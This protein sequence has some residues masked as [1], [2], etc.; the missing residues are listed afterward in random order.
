Q[1]ASDKKAASLDALKA[2]QAQGNAIN[3]GEYT[4]NSYAPLKDALTAAQN[5]IDNPDNHTQA[6]IDEATTAIQ[7]ALDQLSDKADKAELDAAISEA[8]GLDLDNNDTEDKA[9]ADALARAQEVSK[10]DNATAEEVKTATDALNAAM[11]AKDTQDA[12]DK[13]TASLDA[14]K[15]AQAQGNAIDEDGYT[16]NSYAPLKDALTAAQNIIDNPEDHTQAEIDEATTAI[17]DALDQLSDR[18]DKAELDTAIKEAEGLDLDETDAEDKAVID[19][20]A[21]AK[22]VSENGNATAE[23]VKT[24]T[25]ALNTAM[26]A[27]D[28]QDASDKKAASLDALKAA[29]AQGNAINEGEY[30]PN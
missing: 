24:A 3:E 16:P 11:K 12:S 4:P 26:K 2:A 21:T 20:L 28:T 17:Q 19:A 23:E 14:L 5:I 10:D 1:D 6:E 8:E 13:K 18:A 29:Q 30:T 15:A 25:D 7:D 22:E 9:V 27:K